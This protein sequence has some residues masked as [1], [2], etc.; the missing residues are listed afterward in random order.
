MWKTAHE[1][2]GVKNKRPAMGPVIP[3]YCKYC[4]IFGA[5]CAIYIYS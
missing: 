4:Q 3:V 1:V 2:A 5:M